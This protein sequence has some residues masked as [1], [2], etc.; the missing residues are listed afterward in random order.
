MKCKICGKEIENGV[1]CK[2]CIYVE[3]WER[4]KPGLIRS[5]FPPRIIDDILELE[6]EVEQEDVAHII[7]NKKGLFIYGGTGT[8]KTIYA[9]SLLLEV[10]KQRKLKQR[11]TYT[12]SYIGGSEFFQEIRETL[13]SKE[14]TS[15]DILQ[16][17][18]EVDVL[19]LD[20]IGTEKP[21]DWVFQMLY[22]LVNHRY[23]YLKPTII[24]SNFGLAELQ[25]RFNDDRIPSRIEGM[26]KIKYFEG[27]DF[28]V[29]GK[30]K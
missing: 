10:M 6:I 15:S 22:L 27:R 5:L 23:E 21:S 9:S 30:G 17:Y 24:V 20:E 3:R 14:I 18:E 16:K 7:E 29:T 11:L 19:I 1:Q 12:G 28:R 25:E 26:C 8:G 13:N 2:D 4:E